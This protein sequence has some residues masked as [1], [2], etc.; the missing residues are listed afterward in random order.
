L[1]RLDAIAE[2]S[3]FP[4]SPTVYDSVASWYYAQ[5]GQNARVVGWLKSGFQNDDSSPLMIEFD[6]IVRIRCHWADIKYQELLAFLRSRNTDG[7]ILMV[8][9]EFKILEA[10]C[11]YQTGD[12]AG[13]QSALLSAYELSRTN[14][15]D[16]LFIEY[17][18]KM[19]TLSRAAMKA[20]DCAIPMEWLTKINKKSATYAKKL[21]FVVSEYRK[22]NHLGDDVHLSLREIEILT[23]LYHGLSRSEIAANRQ[24]SINTVKSLLQI[25]YAKL[26]AENNMDVIRI[27]LDMKLI[28]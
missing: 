9:I 26:G 22:S 5:L 3:E 12:K 13:A 27:A 16:M 23:D 4:L 7:A 24:L 17:G 15:F 2:L 25:I 8:R 28:G 6:T 11:L 21:A 18:N 20:A 19:R 1:K 14:A 10:I